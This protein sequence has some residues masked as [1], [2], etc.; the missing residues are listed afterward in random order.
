MLS[1]EILTPRGPWKI[2]RAPHSGPAP[3][4]E[5][6]STRLVPKHRLSPGE[7]L[8]RLAKWVNEAHSRLTMGI[9]DAFNDHRQRGHVFRA[10]SGLGFLCHSAA[11]IL[12]M[13]WCRRDLHLQFWL[14]SMPVVAIVS[15]MVAVAVLFGI[16]V[17]FRVVAV[18]RRRENRI[19]ADAIENGRKYQARDCSI[20]TSATKQ[21]LYL[22]IALSLVSAWMGLMTLSLG[23]ALA[24]ELQ[25]H[26]GAGGSS[27]QIAEAEQ[28]LTAFYNQ[29]QHGADGPG[30]DHPITDCPGF[31]AAFPPP[32]PLVGYI[33]AAEHDFGC[34]GFCRANARSL[35][36]RPE[37]SGPRERCALP[38]SRRLLLASRAIGGL[39]HGTGLA[40]AFAAFS[41]ARLK[42]L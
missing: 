23:P 42:E 40:T 5:E 37:G 7:L 11:L 27:A 6:E 29:C 26:C 4:E 17:Q 1:Q 8:Q 25:K 36:A 35:F 18:L 16:F 38:I 28:K 10:F 21:F 15:C 32:A 31:A 39:S 22:T 34:A 20:H 19:M 30:R 2:D 3:E 13:T 14:E 12:L 9:L 33:K 24:G 41:L